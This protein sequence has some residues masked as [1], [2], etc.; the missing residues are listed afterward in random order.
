MCLEHLEIGAL[1]RTLLWLPSPDV[2]RVVRACRTLRLQ[3][4]DGAAA[5]QFWQ[6]A[7]PAEG[8]AGLHGESAVWLHALLDA[9]GI[10]EYMQFTRDIAFLDDVSFSSQADVFDFLG[11]VAR[12]KAMGTGSLVV[13][14][15]RFEPLNL[16]DV[17]TAQSST[18]SF[19]CMHGECR[20]AAFDVNLAISGESDGS[21]LIS[22]EPSFRGQVTSEELD[23]CEVELTGAILSPRGDFP[24]VHIN[25]TQFQ[26]HFLTHSDDHR[27]MVDAN[28]PLHE[29]LMSGASVTCMLRVVFCAAGLEQS[30]VPTGRTRTSTGASKPQRDDS[31]AQQDPAVAD[32]VSPFD[33]HEHMLTMITGG[34]DAEE[35]E[36]FL[37]TAHVASG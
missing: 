32:E 29:A 10:A 13:A 1:L 16:H 14:N 28:D 24:V 11:E 37:D 21:L 9:E 36:H 4:G 8:P 35:F 25:G 7:V 22:W 15:W 17:R 33:L 19:C 18:V 31:R 12:A 34:F 6:R 27:W 3:L 30:I 2:F 26:S 23:Y 20:T 5:R